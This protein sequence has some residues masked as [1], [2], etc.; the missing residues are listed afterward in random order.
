MCWAH[1]YINISFLSRPFSRKN[2]QVNIFKFSCRYNMIIKQ[3]KYH[4]TDWT[5]SYIWTCI[6][7]LSKIYLILKSANYMELSRSYFTKQAS[8]YHNTCAVAVIRRPSSDVDPANRHTSSAICHDMLTRDQTEIR[9]NPTDRDN[10]G[11]LVCV[12]TATLLAGGKVWNRT[13]QFTVNKEITKLRTQYTARLHARTPSIENMSSRCS[14]KR[15]SSLTLA[16]YFIGYR[17]YQ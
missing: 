6:A 17:I 12:V 11:G 1:H 14:L 4:K 5:N 3:A 7:N 8:K 16:Q 13:T 2:P 9:G 15:R 10:G